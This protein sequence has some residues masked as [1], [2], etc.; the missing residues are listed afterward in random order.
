MA[1]RV[2]IRLFTIVIMSGSKAFKKKKILVFLRSG[3][4]TPLSIV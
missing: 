4:L 2:F 1:P 3:L